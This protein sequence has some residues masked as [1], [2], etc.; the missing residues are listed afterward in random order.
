MNVD[1]SLTA[2]SKELLINSSYLSELF[3]KETGCS[4]THFVQEERIK[5]AVQLF[6]S[7]ETSVQIIAETVG[8]T[9]QNYFTKVFKKIT[10]YTPSQYLKQKGLT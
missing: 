9:D 5:V 2:I 4:L 7:G 10:H 8:Y 1:L 3:K 6:D